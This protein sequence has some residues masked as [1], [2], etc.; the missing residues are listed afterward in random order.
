MENAVFQLLSCG[1]IVLV[2]PIVSMPAL[3]IFRPESTTKYSLKGVW[4][5][6]RFD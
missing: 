1:R 5:L 2:A 6:H 3:F 4:H